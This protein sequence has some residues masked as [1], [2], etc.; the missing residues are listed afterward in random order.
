[1]KVAAWFVMACIGL[2]FVDYSIIPS[3]AIASEGVREPEGYRLNDYRSPVP[4]T[5]KGATV[6]DAGEADEL[7][8]D[9]KGDVLFIDVYPAPPKPSGL[10]KGTI[11]REP[12]HTSIKGAYWLGNVGFGV[13][14]P[15]FDAY[16]RSGLKRL[17]GD[18]KTK[19][20]VFFCLRDC[21][22]SWN[23]AKRALSYGYENVYWFPDGTD[24]WK[25]FGLPTAVIK[26]EK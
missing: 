11:W 2:G 4:R 19:P 9:G 3:L 13:L 15:K 18:D 10:P 23:A 5:L 12:K 1:M 8:K 21:W 16:F 24:G 6:I 14:A 20:I 26:P 22:M 17:S 25:D 7:W